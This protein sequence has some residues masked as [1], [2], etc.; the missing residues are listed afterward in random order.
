MT[1]PAGTSK[2]EKEEEEEEES[3]DMNEASLTPSAKDIAL[4]RLF[5]QANHPCNY[6][7]LAKEAFLKCLG[8]GYDS[9]SSSK[10]KKHGAK[11]D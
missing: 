4:Y 3:I 6:F 9:E 8:L 1:Y 10:K 7:D 5:G 11:K 2:G